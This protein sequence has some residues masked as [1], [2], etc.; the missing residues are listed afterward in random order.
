MGSADMA[1]SCGQTLAG[2]TGGAGQPG[3]PFMPGDD[4]L[5]LDPAAPVAIYCR[6]NGIHVFTIDRFGK[7]TLAF[8]ASFNQINA[9]GIPSVNTLIASGGGVGLFRL[10]SGEFQVNSTRASSTQPK[11]PALVQQDGGPVIHVVQ[12]GDNLFR[13][14]LRYGTTIQAIAAANGIVDV[15]RI[16]VGQQLIIPVGSAPPGTLPGAN[17]PAPSSAD[18]GSGY[19]FIFNG[20]SA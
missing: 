16:Y 2:S 20:C 18:I 15:T 1:V 6:P 4:R 10:T 5:N 13:I 12:R 14:A 9:V 19:V 3:P 11:R 8:I 7:G 17:P